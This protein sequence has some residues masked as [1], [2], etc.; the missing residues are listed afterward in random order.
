M[1]DFVKIIK[2]TLEV[3]EANKAP[4]ERSLV[5]HVP[6]VLIKNIPSADLVPLIVNALESFQEALP[7]VLAWKG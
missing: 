7:Q 6:E 3:K 4:I 1:E 2:I 5:V